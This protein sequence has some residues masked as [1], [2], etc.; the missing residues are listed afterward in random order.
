MSDHVRFLADENFRAGIVQ[1]LRRHAGI[2]ILTV[3]DAGHAGRSDPDVLSFAANEG[4]VLISHDVNTMP[5]FFRE[6]LARGEQTAGIIL[7]SQLASFHEAI[8]ALLL[9]WEASTPEEWVD[10]LEFLPWK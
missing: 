2:D 7:I 4:R 6:M 8:E 5:H 1:G 10:H 9:V 3:F